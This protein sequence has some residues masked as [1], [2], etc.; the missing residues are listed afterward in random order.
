[1]FRKDKLRRVRSSRD[2]PLI[3]TFSGQRIHQVIKPAREIAQAISESVE[4]CSLWRYVCMFTT[5]LLLLCVEAE[6]RPS[7]PLPFYSGGSIA[8]LPLAHA[9]RS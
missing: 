9:R 6:Y 2:C 4:V 7:L 5:R 3:V 1:M 8:F